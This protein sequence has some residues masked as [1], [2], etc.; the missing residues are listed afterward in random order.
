M[1]ERIGVDWDCCKTLGKVG[2]EPE[3]REVKEAE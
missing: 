1:R 3:V 2:I